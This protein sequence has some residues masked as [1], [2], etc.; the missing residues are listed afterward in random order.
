MASN[1]RKWKFRNALKPRDEAKRGQE[2]P[3]LILDDIV[4]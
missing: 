4:Q 1:L 3:E 2:D